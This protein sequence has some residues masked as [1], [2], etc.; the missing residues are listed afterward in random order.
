MLRCRQLIR[1]IF[2]RF[3]LHSIDGCLRRTDGRIAGLFLRVSAGH[4]HST[5]SSA[6][7]ITREVFLAMSFC[8]LEFAVN[9]GGF[10]S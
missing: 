3:T 2:R 7:P 5:I 6:I 10:E 1:H 8:F 4:Q 9:W